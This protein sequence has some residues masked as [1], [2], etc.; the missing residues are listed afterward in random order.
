MKTTELKTKKTEKTH[1]KKTIPDYSEYETADQVRSLK[2]GTVSAEAQKM[3]KLLMKAL[4][5]E[6]E[7]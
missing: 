3:Y 1:G 4:A 5:D 6:T 7:N 2:N